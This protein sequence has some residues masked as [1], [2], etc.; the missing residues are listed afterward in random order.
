MSKVMSR[1]IW[2]ML[3]ILILAGCATADRT[4]GKAHA[5]FLKKSSAVSGLIYATIKHDFE[6]GRIMKARSKVLA[7]GK[8]DKDYARAHKLLKEKI[9][10]ARR[11]LFVHYLRKAKR[12]E[13]NK[14][15]SEAMSAYK[16][17][18]ETTIKPE[19][20]ENKR[21]KMEYKLRQL[22]L[23][24]L[25][26]QRRK[27]DSGLLANPNAYKPPKGTNLK[28]EVF[29]RKRVQHE[30]VL[31]DRAA[32]AYREAKRSL[33]RGLPEVA[34]VD[35]ESYLRLQPGSGRGRALLKEIREATPRQLSLPTQKITKK[36]GK[37]RKAAKKQSPANQE[38]VKRVIV[39]DFISAE[40]IRA[41]MQRGEL[42]SARQY[43][44]IYRREGG[45][46]AAQVLA[47]IQKEI[48]KEA[49]D[50]FARGG[51]AFRQEHLNR[52]IQYWSDAVALMPEEPE[53]VEALRRAHQ[54][55]ERLIL[56][57]QASDEKPVVI[58]K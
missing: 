35:I 50:L 18:K 57:R 16:Q 56:L 38:A 7:M 45:K 14:L 9:E 44:Q 55:K 19:V 49:S 42:L 43:A 33:R 30:E 12:A 23:N 24:V 26:S 11:R 13:A 21:L 10:P 36:A 34:Y 46:D 8:S 25:L 37:N 2:Y 20:M 3:C 17:A 15:W 22:R 40:Q 39:P 4:K 6:S 31:D 41:L 54:L 52:A 28:D 5:G 32:R 27:E 53:Y 51:V 58:E 47:K 29:R 1:C 48:K